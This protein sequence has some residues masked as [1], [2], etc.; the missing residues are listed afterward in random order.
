MAPPP[1]RPERA[2][3]LRH[4]K[5]TRVPRAFIYLDS[6][7]HQHESR[8]AKVQTFRLGVAAHDR[9]QH[10]KDGWSQREW[11][12]F[13][14]TGELWDWIDARCQ[15]K[16]R[17]VLV[18]HKLD[19]D[20]RI[21]D[22]LRC[23]VA[24][25]WRLIGI[26]LDTTQ[27]W[28]HWKHGNRS[29][30]MC[31]SL[32]WLPISLEKVGTLVGIGK[33]ALP[34]WDD[35]DK[36]WLARCRRDVE[37]L[38][39]AYRRVIDWVKRD[40]LGNWKA[41]G[42][43][44]AWAAYRH[45]YMSHRLLVHD[46]ADA[47]LA[48]REACYTGRCEAWRWG[49]QVG[50]PFVEYDY[51]T[52][53]ARIGKECAVPTQLVGES[54]A[55]SLEQY[56]NLAKRR[57]LLSECTITTDVP[58]VPTRRDGRIVWPVGTFTATLWDTEVQLAR[59]NGAHV[60]IGHTWWYARKP[61]IAAFCSWCLDVLNESNTDVDPIVRAA[62]KHWSRALVG[63][64]AARWSEWEVIGKSPVHDV[65]LGW[66]Q[67]VSAGERWRMLQL[68]QVLMRKTAE[69]DS[70]DAIVSIMSWIMAE[71][72]ARLWRASVA[73][74]QAEVLYMDTDSLIVTQRGAERLVLAG[75]DG[76]R[77]KG[78]Y[79]TLELLGPRQIVAQGA[80]RASGVAR[81]AVKVGADE[82]ES[83]VWSQLDTSIA[84]GEAD[85]VRITPRRLR[86]RGSDTRRARMPDGTTAPY[87]FAP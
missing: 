62:V 22:A 38:A 15:V 63:R 13:H 54:A 31:D 87:T 84:A 49:K 36:A 66:A 40:D 85:S 10:H 27:A 14:S 1:S 12:E 9:R 28:A 34:E 3:Y 79:D 50:G 29:L 7:A 69:R 18:A 77:R 19:Y 44:Q 75:I 51:S 71:C 43:G 32:S 23:L 52:A 30:I 11:G 57:A 53:Y 67:D 17:T 48:E 78:V 73:A 86:L 6:E 74:G 4:N 58:T 41:T 5:V 83:D 68:G 60:V 33:L 2:H 80:L 21:T 59:E 24:R 82:W 16:G 39:E 26:R 45:K 46:N 70:P 64:F 42:A 47:R 81:G 37:I 20:L 61:A 55:L 8:G 65:S 72:R 35:S 76:F 56:D 25:G